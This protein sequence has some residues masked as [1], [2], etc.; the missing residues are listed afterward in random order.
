LNVFLKKAAKPT[1]FRDYKL[2]GWKRK[3]DLGYNAP[4]AQMRRPWMGWK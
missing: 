2:N 1:F 3:G 4:L